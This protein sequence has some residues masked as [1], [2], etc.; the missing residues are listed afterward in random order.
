MS[1]KKYSVSNPHPLCGQPCSECGQPIDWR[2]KCHEC[3]N[4]R[5]LDEEYDAA[6]NKDD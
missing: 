6:V 5:F 4:N 3:L 2:G 1:E